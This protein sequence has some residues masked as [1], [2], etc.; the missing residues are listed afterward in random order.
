MIDSRLGELVFPLF[1]IHQ[2]VG[3][4]I[5]RRGTALYL[6]TKVGVE[7]LIDDTSIEGDSI[8]ER[9]L[10]SSNLANLSRSYREFK[11]VILHGDKTNGHYATFIDCKG[12]PYVYHKTEW[13]AIEYKEIETF[14]PA[15]TT[16]NPNFLKLRGIHTRL[17]T[18]SM[19]SEADRFAAVLIYRNGYIFM[20]FT[21]HREK[22]HGIKV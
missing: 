14:I 21:E 6:I 19:K 9:R 13:A 15:P 2:P 16:A 10:R 20:G 8:G 3:S 17:L 7:K 18:Y 1:K 5:I 12:T 4:K 22:S 11:D